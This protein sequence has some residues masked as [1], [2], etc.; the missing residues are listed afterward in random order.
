MSQFASDKNKYLKRGVMEYCDE[1][2]LNIEEYEKIAKAYANALKNKG[3]MIVKATEED[4]SALIS[5]IFEQLYSIKALLFSLGGFLGTG[6]FYSLNERQIKKLEVLFDYSQNPTSK[7]VPFDKT[8]GLLSFLSCE[9]K[10]IK[11][12]I[13]LAEQSNYEKQIRDITDSRLT[14]L[15]QILEV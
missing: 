1:Q 8:K 3:F 6:K 9:C 12:L 5:E 15:S 13:V 14:L 10:L 2:I 4:N 7:K 11:N